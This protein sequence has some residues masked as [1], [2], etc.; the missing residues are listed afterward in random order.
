[1]NKKIFLAIGMALILVL[2]GGCSL[3]DKKIKKVSKI[4]TPQLQVG[5]GQNDDPKAL[6]KIESKEELKSFFAKVE[7]NTGGYAP[8]GSA[9][10]VEEMAFDMDATV[11]VKRTSVNEASGMGAAEP[12]FSETNVQVKGVDEADIVKTDGNYLYILSNQNLFIAKSFPAEEAEVLAKI[13][14]DGYPQDLY[15]SDG[16]LV[17][18]G[19]E[20]GDDIIV[21]FARSFHYNPGNTFFKIFDVESPKAPKVLKEYSFEGRYKDS[22]RIGDYVYFIT[23]F[24][25]FQFAE[26]EPLLP[27]VVDAGQE[28]TG[29]CVD[30]TKCLFGEVYY[31]GM[32]YHSY[33]FTSVSAINI[34]NTAE[35]MTRETYVLD[36]TQNIY[37]SQNNLYLTYREYFDSGKFEFD[38]M[39]E[40]ILPRLPEEDK[41]KI[42]T[43]QSQEEFVLNEYEKRSKI[44]Y[45]F[46]KYFNSLE[47]SERNAFEKEYE[48]K[49]K[50][51]Y[52]L[53]KD[54]FE[55]TIIHKIALDEANIE[56]QISGEV[57]GHVI[58]QFSMDESNGYFRIATTKSRSWQE[59]IPE[60]E[61]VSYNNL[62]V[63]DENLKLVGELERLAPDESIYSVRFMQGRAYMVTFKQVDPLFVIDLADPRNPKVLGE[64]KI[65]GF[66]R[67]LHPYDENTLIGFGQ[68]AGENEWGGIRTGGLKMSLF[69][70]SKVAEP[71]ELDTLVLGDAGSYSDALYNHKAFLFS[72]EKSLISVPITLREKVGDN[73]WG[74]LSFRGAA[75]INTDGKSFELKGKIS[76][77]D[78]D[79]C[80]IVPTYNRCYND[81]TV[82]RILYIEDNLYTISNEQVKI[83]DIASLEEV[84]SF[85]LLKEKDDDGE[86]FEIVN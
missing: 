26:G 73:E 48:A 3:F 31:F 16:K 71:K 41:V 63:L 68:E 27:R 46:D 50:A 33:N 11:S 9:L 17:V 24:Y 36:S 81:A 22:R 39:H 77:A 42:R 80:G 65:P 78:K 56:Y 69:D 85:N 45:F 59:Y 74:S 37:A 72:K 8:L 14:F 79:R 84:F 86:D 13:A 1:M 51:E 53:S 35:K 15:L 76:H 43:I 34:A 55:K 29:D 60:E 28:V 49:L 38:V 4:D 66:S 44:H 20:K 18:F 61:K 23:D 30:T 83:N 6:F 52:M 75:V 54:A 40:M 58:N 2:F 10:A 32:P 70:V 64:L 62:Y 57:K 67:Y 82:K 5:E 21:P 47:D 19:S 7:N 25:N 12:D